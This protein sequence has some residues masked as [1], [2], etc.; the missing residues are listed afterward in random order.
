MSRR[1]VSAQS[2][3]VSQKGGASSQWGCLTVVY[4]AVMA[5]AAIVPLPEQPSATVGWLD[6]VVHLCEYLLLAWCWLQIRRPAKL[7]GGF[8]ARVLMGTIGYGLLLEATQLWV[9]YRTAQ[10][11]DALANAIGAGLG[12][13]L[14]V[15]RSSIQR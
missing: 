10:W 5:V 8:V 14:G 11:A 6:K 9:P 12:T 7:S 1:F 4:A 13:W 2:N 15:W 3:R